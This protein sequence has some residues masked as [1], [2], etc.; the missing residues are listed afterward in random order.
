MKKKLHQK[1]YLSIITALFTLSSV[2]AFSQCVAAFTWSQTSANEITFTNTS[3]GGPG[4]TYSWNFGDSQTSNAVNPVHAYASSG[5]YMVC[6]HMY[7]NNVL[8]DTL[9]HPVTVTG[10]V[11]CNNLS[12]SVQAVN[13]SC[14]T[15]ADGSVNSTVS[16]GTPPYSYL[17]S[18]GDTTVNLSGLL[19]GIYTVCVTDSNNCHACA[20]A[21]VW[22]HP[23]NGP[24]VAHF[25]WSQTSPNTIVFVNM[26]TG[27]NSPTYT[28]NFGNNTTSTS[29]NPT[30]VYSSPGTYL[31]CIHMY[32]NNTLCDT[33]CDTVVVTG[34]VN[35]NMTVS[36]QATNATCSTCADGFVNSSVSGGTPPYTYLWSNSST[37]ANL[38]GV[39]PGIYTV[40]VSDVHN[41]TACGSASVGHVNNSGCHA[42]FYIFPDSINPNSHHYYAVNTSTGA[43][44][45]SYLWSW[46][47]S[48]YDTTAYP[49]HTYASAGFYTICLT[50]FDANGCHHTFC[51]SYHL[52][53]TEQASSTVYIN[54]ISTSGIPVYKSDDLYL[55]L[56][57]N[58]AINQL[59]IENGKWKIENV[60]VMDVM[61]KRCLTPTLS[62]GEGVRL[63]VSG[64]SA[65]IYFV[66]VRGE[67]DFAVGKFVKE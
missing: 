25:T 59:T 22:H 41:C 63:D 33:Y 30:Y 56:Y 51:H 20:G 40:C 15:C 45:M 9:C 38:S 61:G 37:T 6:L 35:C 47:D 29:T 55:T 54:V 19:P 1:I 21:H 3:S 65:G 52:A 8:C 2:D 11:N 28:W 60:E 7:H 24:C 34:S 12:V 48:T 50:I 18:N 64:L 42:S 23:N 39:L 44:P 36:A 58:P 49:S 10:N 27:G 67:K 57:P 32:S 4:I 14:G 46:G 66:R 31:V 13:A 43:Q 62:E 16:G 26:S 5:T 53:R 17:W